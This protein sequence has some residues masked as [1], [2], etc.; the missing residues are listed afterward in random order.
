MRGDRSTP[1]DVEPAFGQ[2]GG[3]CARSAADVEHRA[4]TADCVGE[5]IHRGTEPRLGADVAEARRRHHVHVVVSHAVVGIADDIK[6]GRPRCWTWTHGR[7]SG[8][9]WFS[10]GME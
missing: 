7:G 10:G 5:D 4:Q 6:I 9:R 3:D 1:E 8:E 2:V